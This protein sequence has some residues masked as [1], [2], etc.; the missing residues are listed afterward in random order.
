MFVT[1]QLLNNFKKPLT[2]RVPQEL[3]SQMVRGALVEVP[4]RNYTASAFVEAVFFTYKGPYE[5][6][7]IIGIVEMPDDPHYIDFLKKVGFYYQT[8]FLFS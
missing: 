6:R 5:V 4:L 2:Y 8:D 3:E 7:D 1:V